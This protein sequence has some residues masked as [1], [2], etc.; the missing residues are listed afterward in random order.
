MSLSPD[1]SVNITMPF[2][3]KNKDAVEVE[4]DRYHDKL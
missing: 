4:L 3:V 1:S 2:Y